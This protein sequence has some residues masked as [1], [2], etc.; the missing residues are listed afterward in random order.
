MQL[1]FQFE[2]HEPVQELQ[3]ELIENHH[4]AVVLLI[5]KLLAQKQK[6]KEMRDF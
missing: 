3:I 4:C 6:D 1:S 2:L 5:L